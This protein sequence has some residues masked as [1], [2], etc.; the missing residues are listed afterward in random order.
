[1]G[2][3]RAGELSV[4]ERHVGE[5]CDVA[6]YDIG[7]IPAAKQTHLD[8]SDVDGTVGEP[9]KCDRRHDVEVTEPSV[10]E[11]FQFGD[12]EYVLGKFIVRHRQTI[13]HHA[14]IDALEMGA[15]V[16]ADAQTVGHQQ[17]RH[18]LAR[19]AFAVGAGDVDGAVREMRVAH[20]LHK[21]LNV[22]C[23]GR[24]DASRLLVHRMVVEKGE[25][26]LDG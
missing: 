13:D 22:C 4:V 19:A 16:R 3:R 17:L 8:D 25:C 1:M 18:H 5:H 26:T 20:Q 21:S 11:R 15:C 7:C 14:F 23:A 12:G 24:V 10:D 2:V 9:T 6:L